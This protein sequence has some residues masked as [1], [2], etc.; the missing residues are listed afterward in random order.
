MNFKELK[1]LDLKDLLSRFTGKGRPA[2]DEAK[3]EAMEKVLGPA[4]EM[5]GHPRNPFL[6][7]G[8]EDGR[9]ARH[10]FPMA[11]LPEG[12][13]GYATGELMTADGKG[14]KNADGFY[15]LVAFTRYPFD[16]PAIPAALAAEQGSL[17]VPD[18]MP[19]TPYNRVENRIWFMLNAIA[20]HVTR[21]KTTLKPGE[22]LMLPGDD[23]G[24][25]P[26]YVFFARYSSR[27]KPFFTY[28][29]MKAHLLLAME[30]TQAEYEKARQVGAVNM[31]NYLKGNGR[32]PYSLE[33]DMQGVEQ[34]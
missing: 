7:K 26:A 18:K 28:G 25:P 17:D 29:R 20:F 6:H 16:C 2:F 32:W 33:P 21:Q 23:A 4:H 30:L 3:Q 10:Y 34:P 24:Q 13:T 14:P 8:P 12:G 9:L 1:D 5:V 11:I 31:T 27:V 19:D 22:T 15:E